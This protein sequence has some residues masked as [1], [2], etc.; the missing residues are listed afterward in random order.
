MDTFK[1]KCNPFIFSGVVEWF[2]CIVFLRVFKY[3]KTHLLL[4]SKN[5]VLVMQK[6]KNVL[7]EKV[8]IMAR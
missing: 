2:E 6:A 3:A 5:N 8:Y 7:E 4:L 1:Q